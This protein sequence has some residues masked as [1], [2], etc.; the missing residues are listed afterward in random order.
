MLFQLAVRA[1]TLSKNIPFRSYRCFVYAYVCRNL[2][3]RLE[4]QYGTDN[5][6]LKQLFTVV[7]LKQN[8]QCQ[9]QFGAIFLVEK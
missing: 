6:F 9:V 5:D 1:F 2:S 7:I 3:G 4:P 8:Y